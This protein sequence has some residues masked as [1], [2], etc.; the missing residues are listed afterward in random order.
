MRIA[1]FARALLALVFVFT[2]V[3]KF[4]P[5]NEDPSISY[6]ISYE[7]AVVVGAVEVAI[8]VALTTSR[9]RLASVVVVLFSL[10]AFATQQTL[11]GNADATSTGCG[12][13]GPVEVDTEQHLRLLGAIALLGTGLLIAGRPHGTG[14]GGR[15][16]KLKLAV[17]G[18]Q[19]AKQSKG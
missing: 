6:L 2:G 17:P 11:G 1:D 16:E 10:G 8:A 7:W 4:I 14:Q 13:F 18:T 5:R 9:W 15:S 12:C 19:S 3:L